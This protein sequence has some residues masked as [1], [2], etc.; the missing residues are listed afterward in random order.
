MTK[1][2]SFEDHEGKEQRRI[3]QYFRS[4]YVGIEIIKSF[5]TGTIAFAIFMVMWV[6]YQ[7][8]YLLEE[9]NKIDLIAFGTEILIKYLVFMAVYFIVT[10]VVYN[11]RYSK[12][13]KELKLFYIRLKKVSHL[14]ESE[15]PTGSL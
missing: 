7:M 12:G 1:L 8:E 15:R 10:Y 3:R 9:I 14:Y 6:I 13:R 4:D 5:L 11:V 2:A